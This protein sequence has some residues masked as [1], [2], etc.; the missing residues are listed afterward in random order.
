MFYFVRKRAAALLLLDRKKKAL[1]S[2]KYFCFQKQPK[3]IGYVVYTYNY[4]KTSTGH[5]DAKPTWSVDNLFNLNPFF[6]EDSY[7]LVKGIDR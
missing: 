3:D 1:L 2:N 6:F 5:E 7:L 4:T